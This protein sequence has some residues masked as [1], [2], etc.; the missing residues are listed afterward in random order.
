[1]SKHHVSMHFGAKAQRD[2]MIGFDEKRLN[3][4]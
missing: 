2:F 3:A 4:T 1:M